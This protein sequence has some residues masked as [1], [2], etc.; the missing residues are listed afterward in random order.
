MAIATG[1]HYETLAQPAAEP[2]ERRAPTQQAWTAPSMWRYLPL[3]LAAT[4]LVVLAPALVAVAIVPRGGA[5]ATV[6]SAALAVTISLSLASAAA[7]LWRRQARSRDVVFAELMLWGWMRRWWTEHRLAQARELIETVRLAAPEV[8]VERLT[9]LSRLIEARD[10]HLH[11]HSRRVARHAVRIGRTMGL[12]PG[13]V[14]KIRTAAEV[15][16]VGKLYTPRAILNKPGHL[17]DAE[18]AIVALH[19]SDGARIVAGVGDAEIT[20]MVRHHHERI[21]GGGYPDGLAGSAI[22]LGARIIAVADTFDAITSKRAYRGASSQKRALDVLAAGAGTQLDADAVAAFAQGCSARRSV[23]WTALAAT[24][25]ERIASALVS[26]PSNLGVGFASLG[27]LAPALG[28]A[29]VLA[30]SPGLFR[31]SRAPA[32]VGSPATALVSA[33]PA[34]ATPASARAPGG[35]S[36]PGASSPLSPAGRRDARTLRPVDG[37]GTTPASQ[38]TPANT[39]T[40]TPAAGAP[41]AAQPAS[42]RSPAGAGG[43]SSSP[44]VPQQPGAGGPTG[45]LPSVTP[46]SVS[47]PSVSTPTVTTPTVTTP[48]ATAPSV[49]TPSVTTPSVTVGSAGGRSVTVPS[50]TIPSVE[51]PDVGGR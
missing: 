21:D 22:P 13:E 19:A 31:E 10:S 48:S 40:P 12:S 43:A 24:A 17:T 25:L 51:L 6:G 23:A 44:S 8:D 1:S 32:P 46:P 29:G 28:A 49:S 20:A 2:D 50:V 7:A 14:A 30:V 37:R 38:T 33:L 39:S 45:S 15:H 36:S 26:T 5:L 4:S 34:R 35:A 9:R 16:D 3:A 41:A 27:S 42:P 11:G 47:P 18:F